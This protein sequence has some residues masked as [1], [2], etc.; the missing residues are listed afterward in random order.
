MKKFFSSTAIVLGI[1]GLAVIPSAGSVIAQSGQALEIG[2]P[3]VS[4]SGNPG[5]TVTTLISLRGVSPSALLVTS[6]L[7]DFVANG[8][9]GTPRVILADTQTPFSLKEW[10]RP[11]QSLTLQPRE[12]ISLQIT[13]DIPSNA[14]PGGYY[15]IVRFTGIPPELEGTGVSL[16]ASLG[17]LI[18]LKVN[19]QANESLTIEELSVSSGGITGSILEGTPITVSTR[20]KNTGNTFEQPIGLI[21]IKDLFGNVVATLPV[22]QDQRIILSDSTRK[23]DQQLDET[24]IGDRFLFGLYSAELVLNYGSD[25]KEEKLALSFWVIPYRMIAAIIIGL[26]IAFF[27]LRFLMRRYNSR[28]V[29]K[30][31][32]VKPA[33]R[34]K[35]ARRK[36]SK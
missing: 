7:N 25:N 34:Q 3:V 13:I 5:E 32:G 22:N 20:I 17:S 12:I 26:I 24:V 31:T 36:K 19:G 11:I 9:D 28:V 29:A 1:L 15:G 23:Y 4:L 18:F 35:R 27:S 14:S 16:N 2:P 10:V 33:A 6:E 30:A 8:E 21:T